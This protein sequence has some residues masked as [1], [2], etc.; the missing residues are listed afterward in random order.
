MRYLLDT[1]ALIGLLFCPDILS[2]DA[3]RIMQESDALAVSIASL[4]ELGI[5]QSIGKIDID[6]SAEDI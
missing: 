2:E 3:N 1:N 4:W 5:K 6:A